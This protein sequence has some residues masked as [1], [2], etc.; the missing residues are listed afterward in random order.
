[1]RKANYSQHF[2]VGW[3]LFGKA[4]E[5]LLSYGPFR[6]VWL[7]A[8]SQEQDTAQHTPC[9]IL[10]L[11][12]P[13]QRGTATPRVPRLTSFLP[14][15]NTEEKDS[16]W[17]LWEYR[18]SP[19]I[20]GLSVSLTMDSRPTPGRECLNCLWIHKLSRFTSAMINCKD[21]CLLL[22]KSKQIQAE[23]NKIKRKSWPGL[24]QKWQT[25]T[26]SFWRCFK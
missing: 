19:K 14:C 12:R 4:E 21:V 10:N 25:I 20:L 2:A 22:N 11:G 26:S 8:R 23:P 9:F 15:A 3:K 7:K 17:R 1:M 18:D 6:S 24:Y 16:H 5:G 13:Y